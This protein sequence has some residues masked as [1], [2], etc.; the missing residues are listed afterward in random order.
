MTGPTPDINEFTLAAYHAGR[1]RYLRA[2]A[3]WI[4]DGAAVSVG[5]SPA[6]CERHARLHERSVLDVAYAA[7]KSGGYSTASRLQRASKVRWHLRNIGLP[8]A[9]EPLQAEVRQ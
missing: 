2:R 7:E 9:A 1:A 3:K 5:P 4:R 8:F 6:E